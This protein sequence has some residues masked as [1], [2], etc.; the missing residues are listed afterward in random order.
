VLEVWSFLERKRKSSCDTKIDK[1]RI[2]MQIDVTE[3]ELEILKDL[4]Q[5][6]LDVCPV[7]AIESKVAITYEK[8]EA[9]LDKLKSYLK[10]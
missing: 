9:L 4:V 7:D 2:G 10:T 3:E 1:E 5:Y 8:V 6:S